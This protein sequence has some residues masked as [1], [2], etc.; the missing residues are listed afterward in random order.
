[1]LLRE[2]S[3]LSCECVAIAMI[4][5]SDHFANENHSQLQFRAAKKLEPGRSDSGGP[6][7]LV[8]GEEPGFDVCCA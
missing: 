6:F 8:A 7:K 1:M 2:E 5:D 4:C 3:I